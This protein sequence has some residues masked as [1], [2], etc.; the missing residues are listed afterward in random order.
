MKTDRV[1]LAEWL[2]DS[3]DSYND[4]PWPM[5]HEWAGY[6][7]VRWINQQDYTRCQMILEKDPNPLHTGVQRLYAEFYDSALRT[8]FALRFAK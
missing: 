4:I 1:L 6:D 3:T 7:V 8:E 2:G 5:V